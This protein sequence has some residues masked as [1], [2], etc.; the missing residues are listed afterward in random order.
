MNN[1]LKTISISALVAFIV[2][3]AIW[4]ALPAKTPVIGANA[5]FGNTSIDGSQ[6]NLPNP[7]N[8]DYEVARLALGFGTN[9]SNSNTGAGNVNIE[10]QRVAITAASTTLCAIQ[11]PFNAT[12][13]L[14]EFTMNVTTAS[15]TATQLVIGSSTNAFSPANSPFYGATLAASR[16]GT[17]VTGD[18]ATST[19]LG[20]VLGP[21]DWMI[22]TT[23]TAQTLGG[24]C[25]GLFVSI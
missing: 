15:S 14:Q 21:T 9:L 24:T 20:V 18:T 2:T 1:T 10:G 4:L 22:V 16:E 7:S 12:S 25:S 11:N 5:V 13:T 23:P 3:G 8:S 6:A 19:G 17:F